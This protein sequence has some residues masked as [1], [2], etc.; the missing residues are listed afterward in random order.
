RAGFNT[1]GFIHRVI[2]GNR[3]LTLEST[4]KIASLIPLRGRPLKYFE[5]L[6]QFNQAKT[7]KDREQN[8]EALKEFK[9]FTEERLLRK[10]QMVLLLKWYYPVILE[11]VRWHDFK[12]DPS[13]ISQRIRPKLYMEQVKNAL[14]VLQRLELIAVDSEGRWYQTHSRLSTPLQGMG[15]EAFIFHSNAMILSQKNLNL[16]KE[17]RFYT[18]KLIS[19]SPAHFDALQQLISNFHKEV[20]RMLQRKPDRQF[21]VEHGLDEAR[22]DQPDFTKTTEVTQLNIQLFKVA[23]QRGYYE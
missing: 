3:N 15:K 12:P 5:T 10:D 13:W 8:F 14:D 17:D 22:L 11:M 19:A 2:K 16:P 21:L 4:R 23:K 20:D 7:Q 6:V 1:S 18:S 9:E